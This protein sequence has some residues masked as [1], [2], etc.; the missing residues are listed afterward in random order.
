MLERV[1]RRLGEEVAEREYHHSGV[2]RAAD[3][4]VGLT[5]AGL[6]VR[7]HGRVVA[8][9]HGGYKEARC[10]V[11]D[12]TVTVIQL[13]ENAVERVPINVRRGIHRNIRK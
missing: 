1:G 5:G 12:R 3:H 4:G 6:A 10:L 8:V 13:R 11:I 7:E 9:Q 2:A